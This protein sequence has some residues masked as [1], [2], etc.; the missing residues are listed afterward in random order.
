MIPTLQSL[1]LVDRVEFDE[2]TRKVNLLG[3]FDQIAVTPGADFTTG[4]SVFFALRGVHGE[5]QLTLF[6]VDLE[7]GEALL[8]RPLR[9]EGSPL[10]TTDFSVRVNRIP[11]P[12]AGSYA[13]ELHCGSELLGTAR[14]E[15]VVN[16]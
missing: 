10:E 8:E 5:A 15:A 16:Q 9:V 3:L 13:W 6:Y 14:V 1:W 7:D 12:H 4:A 2:T 11:V